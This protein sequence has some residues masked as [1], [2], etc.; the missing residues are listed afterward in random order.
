MFQITPRHR[1]NKDDLRDRLEPSYPVV[2]AV[3]KDPNPL[4]W[5]SVDDT[6]LNTSIR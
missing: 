5:V 6:C 2:N 4:T 3:K 1:N